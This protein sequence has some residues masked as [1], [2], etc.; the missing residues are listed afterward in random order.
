[1]CC[2]TISGTSGS[3]SCQAA[4]C[5]SGAYQL[6]DDPS[7]CPAGDTCRILFAT[8]GY[9]VTAPADAGTDGAGEDSGSE[10]SGSDAADAHD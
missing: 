6:C 3:A 5:A 1:V 7:Q 8:Y 9:C 2:G 4:P 10:D